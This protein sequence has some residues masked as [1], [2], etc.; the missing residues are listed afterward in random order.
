[1]DAIATL[2]A[3]VRHLILLVLGVL[4]TWAGTDIVPALNNQSNLTGATLGA[5]VTA[6]IGVLTPLIQSY[7]VG[8]TSRPRKVKPQAR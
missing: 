4:L 2:P 8:A 6:I 7:G 1:M 3:P 5:L